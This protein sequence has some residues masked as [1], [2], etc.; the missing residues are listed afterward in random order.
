MSSPLWA[1]AFGIFVIVHGLGHTA[2]FGLGNRVF[3]V[4]WLLGLIGFVPAGLAFL[5]LWIPREWWRPLI[6]G[7][8]VVSTA[9]ILLFWP[10][11]PGPKLTALVANVGILL[12]VL[13]WY[14]PAPLGTK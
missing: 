13:W 1:Y 7:S 10:P 4:L 3:A 5:G 14:W 12:A 8:V 6:I 9:L 2:G 11:S